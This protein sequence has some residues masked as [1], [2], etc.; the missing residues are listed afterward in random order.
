MKRHAFQQTRHQKIRRL[1]L[2]LQ[3]SAKHGLRLEFLELAMFL[4]TTI[5]CYEHN[6]IN[7][8]DF[9]KTKK[10]RDGMAKLSPQTDQRKNVVLI[11]YNTNIDFMLNC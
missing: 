4:K 3:T 8:C 7:G 5:G 6:A 10:H 1:P 9:S 2:E 11:R